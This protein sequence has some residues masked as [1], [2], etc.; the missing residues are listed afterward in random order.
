MAQAASPSLASLVGQAE[1]Q[2]A[3][4]GM[5]VMDL[6]SGEAL[7]RHR[8]TESYIPASNQKLLTAAACLRG[9]GPNYLIKTEFRLRDGELQVLAGGDPNWLFEGPHDPGRIFAQVAAKLRQAGVQQIRGI[10]PLLGLFQGPERPA[11]WP[12]DQLHKHYCPPSAGLVLERGCILAEI[13]P[14][15]Q[16]LAQVRLLSPPAD[17]HLHGQIKLSKKK[18]PSYGISDRGDHVRIFGH[19][20]RK[21]SPVRVKVA[22]TDPVLHFVQALRYALQQQGIQ[23]SP[24]A[25]VPDL[26]LLTYETSLQ[27]ALLP[28]LKESSNAHAE[29]LLRVLGAHQRRDGSFAGG[30]EAMQEQLQILTP[31]DWPASMVLADGSGLSRDNRLTPGYLGQ[32]IRAMLLSENGKLLLSC[33]PQGGVDGT[34]R[35]RFVGKPAG[36]QVWA[37]TGTIRGSSCLSGVLRNVAGELQVFVIL[38]NSK[39]GLSASSMRRWQ[40]KLVMAIYQEEA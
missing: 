25:K 40:D 18:N 21:A 11:G 14:G 28:M 30:L 10:R 20:F 35:R 32:V 12:T 19:F 6:R 23:E 29:Q 13:R 7:F 31:V 8:S 27:E 26:H 38:M 17:L 36:K 1:R 34:L 4:T 9:L 15:S 16:S 39:K 2:G 3:R 24:S 22:A 5:V 37:K 33:L